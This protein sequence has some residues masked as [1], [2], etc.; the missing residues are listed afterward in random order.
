MRATA[1]PPTG[2]RHGPEIRADPMR[3]NRRGTGQEQD[4][5]SKPKD[6]HRLCK[7]AVNVTTGFRVL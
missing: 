5:M 1:P 4:I 6:V 3:K 7:Y 2:T